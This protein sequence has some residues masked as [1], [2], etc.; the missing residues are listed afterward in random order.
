MEL[1][2]SEIKNLIDIKKYPCS[3]ASIDF[4]LQGETI[5]IELCNDTGRIKFQ[6]DIN[7]A[8]R[9]VNKLTLQLR[10]KK[11]FRLRRIDFNGNHKNPPGP[12]PDDIFLGFEEYSFNRLDHIHFYIEGYNDRWA[13]PLTVLPEIGLLDSDDAYEKM[14]KFFNFCN[15]ENLDIKIRKSLT[16]Y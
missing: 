15:V 14:I 13:L 7:R 10:H 12:A 16:F 4:P 11:I 9:I 2:N 5:D 6:A 1:T 3:S 8:N